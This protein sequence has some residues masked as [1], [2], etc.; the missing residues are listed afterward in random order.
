[1]LPNLIVIGAMKC[2]TTSLH[3]YLDLHPEVHMSKMKETHYF[4]TEKNWHKGLAWYESHFLADTPIRG[5]TSPLYSMYPVYDG[6]PKRMHSLIP[7]VKLIYMVRNPLEKILSTYLHLLVEREADENIEKEFLNSKKRRFYIDTASYF[8]QLEQYLVY[9]SP[10]KILV[11]DSNDLKY[12]TEKTMQNIFRF[13]EIDD[14]FTSEKFRKEWHRSNAKRKRTEL[15]NALE[16]SAAM[17]WVKKMPAGVAWHLERAL[18]YP[19]SRPIEKPQLRQAM[20]TQFKEALFDDYKKLTAFTG[21][22]YPQWGF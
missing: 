20:E 16:K 4:V 8:S 22:E 6:V 18:Y 5:E 10:E 13:L 21:R 15:G 2:G 3:R 11:V 1:M 12:T 19:F 9:F 17:S 7:N 14:T